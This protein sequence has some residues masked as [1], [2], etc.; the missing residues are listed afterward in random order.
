MQEQTKTGILMMIG[1]FFAIAAVGVWIIGTFGS[2]LVC[3]PCGISDIL[4]DQWQWLINKKY[5]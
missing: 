5:W 1:I 2:W 4:S 3:P